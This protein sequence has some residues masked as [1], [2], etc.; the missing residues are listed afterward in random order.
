MGATLLVHPWTRM[1]AGM[2]PAVPLRSAKRSA[3]LSAVAF[4]MY[5]LPQAS[6][7]C[8][9]AYLCDDNVAETFI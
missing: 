3:I 6:T 4:A 5:M 2:I 8:R 1:R 9:E 7:D